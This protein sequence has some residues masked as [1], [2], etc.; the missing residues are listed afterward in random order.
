MNV[1]PTALVDPAARLAP[2]VRVGPF[3]VV[4]PDVELGPGCRLV[5]R[6]TIQGRVRAGRDNVFWPTAVVGGDPQDQRPAAADGRIKIGDGNVFRESSTVHRPKMDGGIT[7]LGSRNRLH[8]GAHVAHDC[9]IGSDVVLG[10]H[11]LLGGHCRVED[12]SWIEGQG[13]VHQF[14]TV[15]RRSWIKTQTAASEDVPPYMWIEGNHFEVRGV[16]PACRTPALERAFETVWRSGL[17]RPEAIAALEAVDD[18][19]V[20]ELAGFLRR[21]AAGRYG[22]ALEAQRR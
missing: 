16:N 10:T 17:P 21:S 6:V 22:R 20:R 15:G 18:P 4:G 3:C 19:Q 9:E 1:H 5:A 11:S 8:A 12:G 14:V 2:D 13:G 7:R